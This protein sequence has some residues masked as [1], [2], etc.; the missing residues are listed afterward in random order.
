MACTCLS[1][2]ASVCQDPFCSKDSHELSHMLQS[3]SRP[4]TQTDL[5]AEAGL[6]FPHTMTPKR[7]NPPIPILTLLD[8]STDT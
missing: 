7:T 4:L 5:E 1:S 6:S 2:T 3:G 8:D